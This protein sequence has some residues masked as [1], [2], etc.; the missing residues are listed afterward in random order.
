MDRVKIE[1]T[2]LGE[3]Y[4]VSPEWEKSLYMGSL[5]ELNIAFLIKE[6]L[7]DPSNGLYILGGDQVWRPYFCR[8]ANSYSY[9]R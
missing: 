8:V 1:L 6:G 2:H 4:V 7:V 5:S 9:R 3:A